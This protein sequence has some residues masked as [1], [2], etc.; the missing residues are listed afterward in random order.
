MRLTSSATTFFFFQVNVI[1]WT[2]Q[3]SD[4]NPIENLWMMVKCQIGNEIFKN[5]KDLMI[6][7]E[8]PRSF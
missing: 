1:P 5:G 2:A 3:S 8:M 7:I 6:Q 4:L